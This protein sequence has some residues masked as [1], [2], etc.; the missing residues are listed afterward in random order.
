MDVEF[1]KKN[2]Y[3]NSYDFF[4]VRSIHQKVPLLCKKYINFWQG[5]S[6]SSQ[7]RVGPP[8]LLMRRLYMRVAFLRRI[9]ARAEGLARYTSELLVYYY[10]TTPA[11]QVQLV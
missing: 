3:K 7:P 11:R 8:L 4:F 1:S 6:R 10:N 2:K 5:L 9:S